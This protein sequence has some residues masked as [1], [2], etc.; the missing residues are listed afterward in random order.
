MPFYEFHRQQRNSF[1][2]DRLIYSPNVPVFRDD[3]GNLLDEPYSISFITSPAP[4]AGAIVK[5]TPDLSDRI[6]AVLKTRSAKI[7][8]LAISLGYSQIILGAW[9][10]GVFRNDPEQIAAV[11]KEHLDT[12]YRNKFDLVVWAI[13]D[14]SQERTTFN[15]FD[16]IFDRM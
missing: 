13:L 2:S 9:G 6:P 7:L 1:Y 12:K 15:T 3:L 14:N 16:R 5:N 4:N 11:F 8:A 10:C